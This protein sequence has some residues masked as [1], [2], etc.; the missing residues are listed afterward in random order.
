V[1]PPAVNPEPAVR[2]ATRG[3][4]P[5]ITEIY[6]Q[7]ILRTTAT[8]DTEPKNPSD[9]VGWFEAHGDRHPILVAVLEGRVVGWTSLSA[10]SDRCAYA[11]TAEISTY[12]A[13]GFRGRGI[14]RRLKAAIL[15]EAVRAGLHTLLA[16]VVEGNAASVHL[17][18]AFGFRT[19]GVMRE[20]GLK[21]GRRLDVQLM[22]LM[23]GENRP[24][25]PEPAAS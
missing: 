5:A 7:A 10:W 20:V 6:N 3:D 15:D 11:D 24:P 25:Q 12:V 1:A 23:L 13:E 18:E 14:G 4:L 8:F 2:R 21:F 16:R 9:Q 17:N 22:Q 19:L